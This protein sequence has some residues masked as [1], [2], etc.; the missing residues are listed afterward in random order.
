MM[1]SHK[2]GISI[3]PNICSLRVKGLNS[4][5]HPKYIKTTALV[6]HCLPTIIVT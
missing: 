3:D 2:Q 1:L 6:Y 5:T 4:S